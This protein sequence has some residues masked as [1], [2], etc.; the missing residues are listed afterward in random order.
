[1]KVDFSEERLG[2]P[3]FVNQII[4][5]YACVSVKQMAVKLSQGIKEGLSE[6]ES[7]DTY[8]SLY[9]NEAAVAHAVFII[10]SFYLSFVTGI[11]QLDLKAVMTKLC[12]LYGL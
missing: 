11:E 10:H 1:M 6:K 8:A 2:C 4:K 9:L 5:Y 12:T 3:A 7:W